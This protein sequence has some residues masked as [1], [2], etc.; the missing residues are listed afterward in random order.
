VR[1]WSL[2]FLIP[3]GR[4]HNL[5]ALGSSE[6]DELFSWAYELAEKAPFHISTVEAPH[7]RRY[8][9][10]RKRAEGTSDADL[11]RLGPRL[12]FGIR[13]GNGVIFVAR[14]GDVY[15]AGFLPNP[16][17]GNVRQVPLHQVYRTAPA[18]ASLRN[19]DALEG[20]C[21]RCQYRWLCGGSRA[22]AWAASGNLLG[23]DPACSYQPSGATEPIWPGYPMA[24]VRAETV[25][26]HGHPTGLPA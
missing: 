6:V 24:Q 22:R 1:R 7:Y 21:G 9:L 3:T 15:P 18:L 17:L 5:L 10:E 20:R 11:A 12:G 8:W 16:K 25:R 23:E 26:G 19:M 14:N 13:D 2:F 4:G